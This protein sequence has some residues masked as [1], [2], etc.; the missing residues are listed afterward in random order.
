MKLHIPFNKFPFREFY[1]NIK[2]LSECQ[3]NMTNSIKHVI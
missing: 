3:E 2:I 1:T